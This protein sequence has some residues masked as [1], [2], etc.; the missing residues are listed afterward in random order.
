[1]CNHEECHKSGHCLAF[2]TYSGEHSREDYISL[3]QLF[4][5]LLFASAHIYSTWKISLWLLDKGREKDELDWYLN[6]LIFWIQI[7]EW[8]ASTKQLDLF[9]CTWKNCQ[10]NTPNGHNS[11]QCM[12]LH[13]VYKQKWPQVRLYTDSWWV[14]NEFAHWSVACKRKKKKFGN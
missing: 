2:L 3:N 7:K 12:R 6:W 1:M 14:M 11:K 10:K 5:T 4:S 13:L 8:T 9:I